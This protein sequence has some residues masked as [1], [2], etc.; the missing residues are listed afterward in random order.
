MKPA[1]FDYVRADSLD[2][3]LDV[4]AAE[5]GDAR[6][7]AGG[8]SLLPML[9][10]R[11][12]RPRVV[13]DIGR[14]PGLDVIEAA[15][16]V[17]V[18]PAGLRQAT[19]LVHPGLERS[20]PL[21]AAALPWV[22]HAQ[23]RARG[24]VCGS[25]AHADPSGELPLCLVAL[26]GSVRLASKRGRRSVDA[27]EFFTGLM[28][29]DRREDEMIEALA[30]PGAKR[31]AGYAFREFGRRHGDFAIVSVAAIVTAV[32]IEI[33]VGGVNDV[34]ARRVWPR[35]DGSALDDALNTLAWELDARD[36]IH[37]DQRLRRD[38]VRSLGRSTIA[39]ASRCLA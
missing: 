25:V 34:P 27:R 19:L 26:G 10:M 31:E 22:G 8:Q 29:T 13:V 4:L 12:A 21:L 37:A 1:L 28:S 7:L 15:K 20:H 33:S 32:A 16:D 14:I 23:T 39:E 30:F 38:L 24:T 35:L 17:L 5:Q 18:V 3:A 6:V 2:E 9:S 36:D 11:L